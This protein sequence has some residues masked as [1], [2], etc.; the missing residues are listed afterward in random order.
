[1]VLFPFI[2]EIQLLFSLQ[3]S[4]YPS[5]F[6]V[7]FQTFVYNAQGMIRTPK[8][9]PCTKLTCMPNCPISLFSP[10]VLFTSYY[11]IIPDVKWINLQNVKLIRVASPEKTD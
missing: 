1:M 4:S 2:K 8:P 9:G 3:N 11:L 5:D 7:C 6:E 10:P